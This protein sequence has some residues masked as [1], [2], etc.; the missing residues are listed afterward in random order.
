MN[1]RLFSRGP[2]VRAFW[3]V[4]V[5]GVWAAGGWSAELTPSMKKDAFKVKKELERIEVESL[6]GR[7]GP[8]KSVDFTET[9]L[10]AWL[11]FRLDEEKEDVLQVLALKLFPENRVEGR[12]YVDLSR[13]RLPLGFK[14]KF[15]LFFSA[16]LLVESGA[17]KIEFTKLFL[18][19][20]QVSMLLLD[21]MITAAS[22]LGK[23]DASAIKEWVLLPYGLK[24]L[25]IDTGRVRL[26]Y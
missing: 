15:N 16:R 2:A 13:A 7:K 8:L 10:N 18:E 20:Q 11:A 5:I 17:A 6:A 14:P 9:E 19:G 3:T 4:V 1:I 21:L 26:Y 22:G 12:A 24:N 23:S 25:R